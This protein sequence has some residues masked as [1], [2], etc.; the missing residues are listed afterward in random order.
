[1]MKKTDT[2]TGAL[3]LNHKRGGAVKIGPVVVDA[4]L[5]GKGIGK[6]LF[7][8]A[9]IYAETVGARKLFATTSHLN[10]PV[11]RLFERDGFNVEATFPDQYKQGSQELVWGK[12]TQGHPVERTESLKV[13]VVAPYAGKIALIS[14]YTESA[15][16]YIYSV[17]DVYAEWH[18]DLGEDFIDGMIAGQQRGL[19]TGLSFQE[20]GKII[21][22]AVT[23]GGEHAGMLTYTPKRGGPVKLY[24]MAGS[25]EAQA[26]L[27]GQSVDLAKSS[28][29]HKLYTF[30]HVEDEAQRELLASQEFIERGVLRSPYKD[31]DD[32][33]ALDRIIA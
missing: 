7:E 25:R 23:E 13:S 14:T 1:M 29:N 5:R 16:S 6:T 28:G 26:E 9:N 12:F 11:N 17:N 15:R 10:I 2:P 21:S 24:P 8:A 20:K 4:A 31:G 3:C 18:D 22:V 30:S 33:V 19:Q 32:L 27:I